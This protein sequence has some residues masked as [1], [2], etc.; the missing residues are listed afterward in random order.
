[1]N[2]VC[3]TFGALA[4]VCVC[5]SMCDHSQIVPVLGLAL[6]PSPVGLVFAL[7][8]LTSPSGHKEI[9]ITCLRSF[10]LS[11]DNCPDAHICY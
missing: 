2:Y 11:L 3:L 7:L 10:F 5:V 9:K 8:L 1:M 4:Y 6:T